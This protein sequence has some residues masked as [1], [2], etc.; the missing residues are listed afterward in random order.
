[1]EK[2]EEIADQVNLVPSPLKMQEELQESGCGFP[3]LCNGGVRPQS[4]DGYRKS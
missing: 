2:L 4:F 3:T 1:M